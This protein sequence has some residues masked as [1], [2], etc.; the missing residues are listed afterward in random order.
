M[1]KSVCRICRL[2]DEGVG[3]IV[4][5]PYKYMIKEELRNR[6]AILEEEGIPYEI[7]YK[8][9]GTHLIYKDIKPSWNTDW[10]EEIVLLG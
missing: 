4:E 2:V 10:R 9:D 7:D 3:E 5:A 1:E 6:I 8:L